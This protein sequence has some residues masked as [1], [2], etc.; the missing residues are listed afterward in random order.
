MSAL[1]NT[2]GIFLASTGGYFEVFPILVGVAR[3]CGVSAAQIS[4]TLGR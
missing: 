2:A 4:I 1:T 3:A